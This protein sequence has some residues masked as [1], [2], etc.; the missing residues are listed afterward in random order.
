MRTGRG[1]LS[2]PLGEQKNATLADDKCKK[3]CICIYYFPFLPP[4]YPSKDTLTHL[5][6]LFCLPT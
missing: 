6:L 1:E 3:G 2:L 4:F 5:V